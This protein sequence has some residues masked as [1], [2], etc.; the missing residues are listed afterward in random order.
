MSRRLIGYSMMLWCFNS[1]LGVRGNDAS[2]SAGV[3]ENDADKTGDV[4]LAPREPQLHSALNNDGPLPTDSDG[5]AGGASGPA[6]ELANDSYVDRARATL[7]TWE[8][9]I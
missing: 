5:S 4:L 9:K 6:Q 7:D 2:S 1:A 3:R 8:N